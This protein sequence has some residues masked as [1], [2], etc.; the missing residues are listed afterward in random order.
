M[1]TVKF[2]SA[3][4]SKDMNNIINYSFGF[5]E[6]VNRGKPQFLA[7][8]GV[9]MKE[10][11]EEYIDSNARVSPETL[12]HVYEW[13]QTG[14]PS[15]RLFDINYTITGVGLSFNSSFRQS[16]AIKEGSS[17]PF[18]D[19]AR[20]MEEGI[21]VTI[22]PKNSTVLAF[23][24]DGETVFTS[25]PVTVSNPG[26]DAVAGSF[27]NTFDLFFSRYLS[28]S[29]LQSS[30]L[31]SHLNNPLDYKRGLSRGKRAGKSA[32]IDAGYKWIVE[33]G[34]KL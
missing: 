17:V 27:K 28:Q 10:I 32:G 18:Y 2:N 4:F 26:G 29:F 13:S 20:I 33:A 14:S 23:D 34:A 11:L 22:T 12:H 7:K 1:I 9:G 8:L 16:V 21:P 24:K 31:I 30:G 5:I 25:G 19:K 15:A 6:G 3:K